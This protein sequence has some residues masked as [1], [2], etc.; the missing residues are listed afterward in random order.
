MR[1]EMKCCF[2]GK[3]RVGLQ[4]FCHGLSRTC[5]A[6]EPGGVHLLRKRWMGSGRI[7]VGRAVFL[8]SHYRSHHRRL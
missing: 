8:E 1:T 4:A 3:R 6:V 7:G 2:V 5:R